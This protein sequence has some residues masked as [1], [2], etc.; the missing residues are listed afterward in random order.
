MLSQI[1]PNS[2]LLTY[3]SLEEIFNFLIKFYMVIWQQILLSNFV[4][5]QMEAI[6]KVFQE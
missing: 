1:L 4:R 3:R 2:L 6:G 5:M